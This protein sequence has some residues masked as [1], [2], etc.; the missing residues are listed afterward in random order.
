MS[1]GQD[2]YSWHYKPQDMLRQKLDEICRSL[3]SIE[4]RL[5]NLE[6]PKKP[7][8]LEQLRREQK[9]DEEYDSPAPNID[10][11]FDGKDTL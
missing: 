8:S 1:D 2:K 5:E 6:N 7:K 3:N 11:R 10:L 9:L 4:K